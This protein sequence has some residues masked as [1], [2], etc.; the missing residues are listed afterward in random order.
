MLFSGVAWR[1]ARSIS[2][3]GVDTDM[4]KSVTGQGPIPEG[5]YPLL[6]AEDIANA[7]TYVL[8]TPPHVQVHEITI[9]PIGEK[10]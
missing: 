7:V 5:E 4:V 10:Y 3:G 6:K 2:P 8:S 9:R 1:V